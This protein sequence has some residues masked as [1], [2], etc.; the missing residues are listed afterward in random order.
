MMRTREQ[1]FKRLQVAEVVRA[2][3]SQHPSGV[4]ELRTQLKK[5]E[6]ELASA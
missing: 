1:L 2:F 6:A 3:I 5:V 4:K